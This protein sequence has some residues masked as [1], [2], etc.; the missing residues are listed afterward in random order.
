MEIYVLGN[1][2]IDDEIEVAGG[3]ESRICWEKN[4]NQYSCEI[5]ESLRQKRKK[6]SVSANVNV[7]WR[8]RLY[9]CLSLHQLFIRKQEWERIIVIVSVT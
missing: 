4:K 8:L 3:A 2:Y 1:L 5:I 9:K 6:R 7:D